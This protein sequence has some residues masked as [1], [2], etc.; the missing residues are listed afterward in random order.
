VHQVGFYLHDYIEMHGQENIKFNETPVSLQSC[1]FS[2]LVR[3]LVVQFEIYDSME[4]DQSNI[5]QDKGP[6][7]HATSTG[8]CP[9]LD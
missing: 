1:E 2:S 8:Y 7:Y 6:Y 4:L 5:R 3:R 9:L